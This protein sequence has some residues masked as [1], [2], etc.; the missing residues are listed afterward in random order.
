[1]IQLVHGPV[2]GTCEH[3]NKL[4]SVI[5]REEFFDHIATISYSRM[6]LLHESTRS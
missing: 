5:K 1:V 4:S 6:T 3:D 2:V